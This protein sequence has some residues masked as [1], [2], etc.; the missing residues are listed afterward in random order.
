M[1]TF[2]VWPEP[3]LVVP[4]TALTWRA[5]DER[6][7]VLLWIG[8]NDDAA[9]SAQ[10]HRAVASALLPAG[11]LVAT[12]DVRGVGETAPRENGRPNSPIMGA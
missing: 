3:D 10:A 9:A 11:W 12:I 7:R 5:H 8:G 1:E 2:Q 4:S 6:K